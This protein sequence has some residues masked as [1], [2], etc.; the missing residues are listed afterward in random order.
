VHAGH[1]RFRSG[2]SH[3]AA[4]D[5]PATKL[6]HSSGVPSESGIHPSYRLPRSIGRPPDV[7]ISNEDVALPLL[8]ALAPR[9]CGLGGTDQ[10]IP[11]ARFASFGHGAGTLATAIR[12][13]PGCRRTLA[14]PGWGSRRL[15]RQSSANPTPVRART[16]T[17]GTRAP[18][19]Q[20][21]HSFLDASGTPRTSQ[22]LV[23]AYRFE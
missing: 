1:G 7:R 2:C 23:F 10:W 13:G 20:F 3:D 18:A 19:G 22:E 14:S 17:P 6:L 12:V 5:A 8:P 21:D 15:N 9:D 4:V 16:P 11:A